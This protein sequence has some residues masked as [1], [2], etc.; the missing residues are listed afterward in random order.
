VTI[1]KIV[2]EII[3]AAG[4]VPPVDR[5]DVTLTDGSPVTEDH[6]EI[7]PNGQQKAYVVLSE[8]ERSRGFIRP[9]RHSYIHVGLAPPDNLRDLTAE[10]IADYSKFGYLKF[11]AYPEDRLPVLGKYWT[12]KDFDKINGCGTLTRMGNAL[13]ETYARDPKFYG[14]TY[15]VGCGTHHPVAEFVWEDGTRVG[16]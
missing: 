3:Q 7:K 13:A 9:V 2:D 16:S 1:K 15:C 4:A 10:E 5:K 6:R 14:S 8:E 11:E 12:Q